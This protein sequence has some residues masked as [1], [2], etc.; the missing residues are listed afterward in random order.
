MCLAILVDEL[1]FCC[2]AWPGVLDPSE[3]SM[4]SGNVDKS[5]RGT[6]SVIHEGRESL[7][8]G[9]DSAGDS[10]DWQALEDNLF[11][12]LPAST[13][14]DSRKI[15]GLLSPKPGSSVRDEVGSASAVWKYFFVFFSPFLWNCFIFS[16]L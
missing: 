3:L 9:L 4:L 15:A 5:S 10:P 8:S 6:L 16:K 2:L 12:E 11:K 14:N 1:S 7:S 13:L